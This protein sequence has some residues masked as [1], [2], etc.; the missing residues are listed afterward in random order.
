MP[1]CDSLGSMIGSDVPLNGSL[2]HLTTAFDLQRQDEDTLR[3][4]FLNLHVM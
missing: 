2:R 3:L 4:V 1:D